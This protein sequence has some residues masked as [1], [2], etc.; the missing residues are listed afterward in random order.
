[1]RG[2]SVNRAVL[3]ILLIWQL[4]VCLAA[5]HPDTNQST[6][7]LDAVRE[8]ADNVLKYGRDTYGPKHT[9]LFVD[10][11]NIHTHEPVKWISPKG[12]V[13]KATETEE[14]ILSNFA[15]QQT[16]LRTLDG[17]SAITG[18]PKYL[19]AAI[20]TIKYAFEN[21]MDH[22][23]LFY[24]GDIAA[25]NVLGD[26]VWRASR[27]HTLKV[28]YPYYELMWQVNPE[29]TRRF[30][31]A[32]WSA[33]VIDWSNLDFNRGSG[34]RDTVLQ[35]PWNHEYM[36]GS[37]F[38]KGK[39]GYG[40][41][42]TGTSLAHA[43]TTLY[44]L[45]DQ[46]Q[47]LVWSERLMQRF[48]D[49]R[50]PNTGISA[51]TYNTPQ[52]MFTNHNMAEHFRNPYTTVFPF[53][54]F[55]GKRK[56]QLMYFGENWQPLPWISLLLT[57]DMLGEHGEEFTQWALE[58]LTAWGKASYRKRD[59]AFVPILTDGTNIEGVV[60]EDECALG[61]KG[62]IA[63]TL[64]AGPEYFWA[65]ATAYRVTGDAFMWQMIRDICAG[66]EFGDIG[67]NP[68]KTPELEID[69]ICSDVYGLLGFLNLYNK[70]HRNEF[71][72]IAR[73]IAD[74]IV[75]T[76]FHKGF[77][78]LSKEHIYARFGCL[79]PL[80]L[81]HLAEVVDSGKSSIPQILPEC[82]I[83]IPPYRYKQIGSDRW[84][85]YR[86]TNSPE[87]P[88]SLQEA[89]HIGNINQV[90]ALLEIGT[91]VDSV[92]DSFRMTALQR[93]A[94]RGHKEI[95][96]W[97][98]A[99][100][101]YPDFHEG[102]PGGTALDF[103]AE[104]GHK[105]IVELLI[106]EG[107]NLNTRRGYPAG[108]T[109]IHSA[110]RAGHKDIV[111]LLIA[112]GADV[113]A[114]NSSGQTPID[115]AVREGRKEIVDLLQAKAAETSIHGAASQGALAKVKAFLAKGVDVNAK[116]D[117]GMTSLHVAAQGGHKEVVEFL[118]SRDADV[119]VQNKAGDTPLHCATQP[120][121]IGVEITQVLIAKGAD[122]DAKNNNGKTP[123]DIAVSLNRPAIA[124]L[125]IEKGAAVFNIHTAAF[126]GNL[127]KVRSFIE[128]GTDVDAKDESGMTP[129]L[130][131]VS[132]EHAA[133]AKFL[134][135][136]R[137]DVNTG[138]KWGYVPLVY[139]L[140]NMD[141]ETVKLL[142]DKGAD[143]NA[144]DT[145]SGYTSLHWAIMMDSKELTEL[146][147]AAGVDVK[148]KSKAG[149][150]PLDVAAYGVS[151]AIGELLVAKGAEVSSLHAAAFV[152][153]L[154]KVKAFIDEGVEVNKKNEMGGTALHSAAV[155]GHKEVAEFLIDNGSDVDAQMRGGLTPLHMAAEA[156]HLD[157]AEL[158]LSRGAD[159]NVKDKRGRTP[160]DLAQK[161]EHKEMV[162][163]L[164]KQ[165]LVHNVAVTKISAAPSCVQGETVS[166]VV[167]LDNRGDCVES[168]AVKLVDATDDREIARQS[169]TIHSKH[170]A[171]SEA[172]LTL[173]GETGTTGSFGN[174]CWADGDV[175]GDGFND[176][177]ITAPNYPVNVD[178]KDG[179]A[180]LYYGGTKMSS[181]G[182]DKILDPENAGDWLGD[183]NGMFADINNDNYDDII[184]GA[185][186]FGSGDEGRVYVYYGGVD[187]DLTP[188]IYLD[189]P[190]GEGT[191]ATLGRG[192]LSAGD[193]NNDGYMDVVASAVRYPNGTTKG[194]VY[195]WYGPLASDTTVDKIFSSEAGSHAFGAILS[196]RGDVNG[197]N[198]DDLLIAHRYYPNNT[199]VGRA[200]LYWGAK[201]TAMDTTADVIFDCPDS[202]AN[203]FGSSAD[204]F[205]IDN[206]GCAEVIIGARRWPGDRSSVGRVYVYWGKTS[207]FDATVGLTITGE[208]AGTSL[209][210]DFV[211][212][213]YADDDQYGDLI[214]T[215]YDYPNSKR[216][217]RAYL[218]YGSTQGEMDTTCDRT[219]TGEAAGF[220]AYRAALSDL[221]NDGYGD[222]VLA[223]AGYPSL[224]G[225]G[226]CLVWYGPFNDRTDITFNWD[227]TRATP[228]KHTLRVTIDPVAGEEDTAD[229][230][231]TVTVEVKEPS[232]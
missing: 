192:G 185:R 125:L 5:E 29:E 215:A 40:F 149:E 120:R 4:S 201:G 190:S 230:T 130:R 147:L 111:E 109:P 8:F 53:H 16:L 180:Y 1:M 97:L 50:H 155:G 73:H 146:V 193:L 39:G 49:T 152:G 227:T 150:T 95:V 191:N 226:R 213:G 60:L 58:E 42:H 37:V 158:L 88:W 124:K 198:C 32:Y 166:I 81:L 86:L 104:N 154:A 178:P 140:W 224:Q 14:W 82:P 76:K 164:L 11:L 18:D 92:D 117:Q 209:G 176:L 44:R 87:V 6:K 186:Y 21:L 137:A 194:R 93:A 108:D 94:M 131:A 127:E 15:S 74:N 199:G 221:N 160:L 31:E 205:D 114:K 188:D 219:F 145:P 162:D 45:S 46:E 72:R 183:N 34:D 112:K 225:R 79:E 78:V 184:I 12:D 105:E 68:G 129:L 19:D 100:G 26:E 170:W 195:L 10:G 174:W 144:K 171:A 70:T 54:P 151:P 77:F 17:L 27:G 89:A 99:K 62:D 2:A 121:G 116:D 24:W 207:G 71:L 102:W 202:G 110:A 153:D 69:T 30:I 206:D 203:E 123:L 143:T 107:A 196:A 218:Y 156:G 168:R 204:L 61:F 182:A 84:H 197:D 179:R 177:L 41:F 175:N 106:S 38:F 228:G 141:S 217:S 231:A 172:D 13:F 208:A 98:L 212:G 56:G 200:Y 83:F 222:V 161:A 189:L 23:G 48:V 80:A 65:Y 118:L 157:V 135:D 216:Q 43:A 91:N 51:H 128:A 36:G 211:H 22:N 101:A 113:D 232:K 136:N 134:V 96:E 59:N 159:I 210:G 67:E 133:V 28:H 75:K 126:A 223:G 142:I 138:D 167:T 169:A 181:A 163:L 55:E 25:Y 90:K 115:L 119:N 187:M 64:F 9:P 47:P 57:G 33:H 173:T 103:A 52:R 3:G 20:Q 214:I 7:Y 220:D 63:K 139:A 148:A 132:G 35:E 229:N 122:I 165:M 85:I 66:N